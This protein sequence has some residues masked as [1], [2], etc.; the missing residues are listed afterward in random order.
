MIKKMYYDMFADEY[1]LERSPYAPPERYC[2][3]LRGTEEKYI[4]HWVDDKGRCVD[5]YYSPDEYYSSIH[6]QR[7]RSTC[8]NY[9]FTPTRLHHFTLPASKFD[10]Y[11]ERF[12][13][14]E[15]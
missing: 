11:V 9:D 4:D 2:I 6:D 14:K 3:T 15:E 7:Y 5:I 12:H 1:V 13:L 8:A 10:E